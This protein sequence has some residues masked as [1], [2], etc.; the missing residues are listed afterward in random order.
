MYGA[1]NLLFT[2]TS[3]S[4]LDDDDVGD[5]VGGWMVGVAEVG[6]DL[7]DPAED[8]RRPHA[9]VV[10]HGVGFEELVEPVPLRGSTT[11]PYSPS[12]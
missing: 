7:V 2:R 12:S 1:K 10:E 4:L 6:A 3:P 5:V 11:W 9:G 8:A